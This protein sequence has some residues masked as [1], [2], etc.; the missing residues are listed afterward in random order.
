MSFAEHFDELRKRLIVCVVSVVL[1]FIF[2]YIFSDELIRIILHPYEAYRASAVAAGGKDPGRL[3]FISLPEGF[4]FYLKTS[5]LAAIFLSAPV[6][7]HQMWVFIGAGLYEKEKKSIMRVVPFSISLFLVGMLF[8]YFVLFPVGMRFLLKFPDSDLLKASI[9]VSMYFNLFF[10]LILI[11]GFVFQAP[12]VMVVTT[13]VGLTTPELFISKRRY[14]LLGAFV[15]GAV[16]TPPDAITQCLLA[17]PLVFLFELGIIL[18]KRVAKKKRAREGR[19]K[20]PP[21]E[22]STTEMAG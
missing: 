2:C 17:G 3:M 18:S 14:F 5:F 19:E 12:L 21:A 1:L 11:M 10:M 6:I 7:L 4:L 9:T 20:D 8:G 16:F 15:I 13:S 22:E